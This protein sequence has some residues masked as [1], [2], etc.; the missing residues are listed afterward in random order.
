MNVHP[1][2][3]EKAKKIK[4]LLTDCDGVLT[5]TGSYYS[6]D[7]EIM[8]RFSIRDGMGVERLRSLVGIETGIITGENSG[9]VT[10]RAAKLK[11]DEVHLG[12]KNKVEVLNEIIKRKN[13]LI[14]EVAFIGDDTNDIEIM[15]LAGLS[16]CPADATKFAKEVSDIIVESNGGYGAFRDFAE[17][18]IESKSIK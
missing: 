2:I 5:D 6:Q 12:I 11:I 15:K 9:I 7:G 10:S 8:K 16:A 14:D 3:I 4:L 1:E 18:L 13:L 17:F